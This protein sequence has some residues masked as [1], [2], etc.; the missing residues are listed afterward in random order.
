LVDA[1]SWV[2]LV[3]IVDP[4]ASRPIQLYV[5]GTPSKNGVFA[6]AP[7]GPVWE[8]T[9]SLA[10]GRGWNGAA[11]DR[12]AGQIDEV[13]VTPRVWEQREIDQK[14]HADEGDEQ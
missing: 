9:G 7:G 1:G 13:Y 6:D 11:S 2:H 4:K 10:I 5:N 8:A 3:G 14:A 12:W